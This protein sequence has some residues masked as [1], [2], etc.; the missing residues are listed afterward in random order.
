MRRFKSR[1]QAQRFLTLHGLVQNFFRFGRH[2][3]RSVNARMF[4]ER[5]FSTWQEVTCVL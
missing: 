2:L 5:A 1:S 3:I 4:R